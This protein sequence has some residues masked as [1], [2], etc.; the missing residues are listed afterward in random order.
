MVHWRPDVQRHHHRRAGTAPSADRY[1]GLEDLPERA[2]G[3]RDEVSEH[4]ERGFP[5]GNGARERDAS[6]AT[7][8]MSRV[9]IALGLLALLAVGFPA[10][11][12][13]P[14]NCNPEKGMVDLDR[15]TPPK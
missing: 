14:V 2:D 13:D 11:A 12:A 15:C 5:E 8:G 10:E 4:L 1:L 3:L 6:E 7:A 9:V